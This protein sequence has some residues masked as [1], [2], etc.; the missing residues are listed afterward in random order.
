MQRYCL[1]TF[2]EGWIK[3]MA[4]TKAIVEYRSE[5]LR[6]FA[7]VKKE[8]KFRDSEQWRVFVSFPRG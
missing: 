8:E 4:L 1:C 3:R 2:S 5:W 6:V 7:S